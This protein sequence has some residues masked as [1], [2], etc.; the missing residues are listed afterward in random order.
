MGDHE[1][2]SAAGWY[3][4]PSSPGQQ[5]YWD[6]SAWTSH[7]SPGSLPPPTEPQWHHRVPASAWTPAPA[8]TATSD[9]NGY[10]T[11]AMVCG[12]IALLFFPIVF[13]PVGLVLAA[14]ARSKGERLAPT[15]LAVAATGTVLGMMLGVL[16]FS[17]F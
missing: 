3:Q 8:P 13:G 11:G 2:R 4:D 9:S 12:A 6:G 14:V 10:A 17:G 5:R 7:T 15:A 1:P 16:L